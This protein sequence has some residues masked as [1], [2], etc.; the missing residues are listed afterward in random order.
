MQFSS[1]LL[2][3][4]EYLVSG[5]ISAGYNKGL[6]KRSPGGGDLSYF[7]IRGSGLKSISD[8]QVT[9][10]YVLVKLLTSLVEDDIS[11]L[12]KSRNALV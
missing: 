4:S 6:K 7:G 5:Y 11:S 12:D 1:L 10:D 9:V 2:P 8:P 3:P